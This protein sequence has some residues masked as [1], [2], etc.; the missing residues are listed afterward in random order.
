[1]ISVGSDQR[2]LTVHLW[3][4]GER[5][6]ITFASLICDLLKFNEERFTYRTSTVFKHN[7]PIVNALP[8][9]F[10]QSG[11]LDLLVMGQSSSSKGKLD[12]FLYRASG[13]G[14]FGKPWGHLTSSH[15]FL[16]LSSRNHTP[17]T[18]SIVGVPT[19]TIRLDRR[20]TDRSFRYIS[21]I[22][23]PGILQYMEKC[24]ECIATR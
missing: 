21:I 2:T 3:D 12:L 23:R 24:M 5:Q 14:D 10:T 15:R 6:Y 19:N 22:G 4:H 11:R 20:S 16:T 18:P 9:D 7:Q 17:G 13:T 1:M 8:G